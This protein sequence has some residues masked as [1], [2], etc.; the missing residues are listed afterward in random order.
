MANTMFLPRMREWGKAA[1]FA[2]GLALLPSCNT[3]LARDNQRQNYSVANENDNGIALAQIWDV[4]KKL[5]LNVC[6]GWNS[7]L[8]NVAFEFAQT[9]LSTH[10]ADK[11]IT[12]NAEQQKAVTQKL[13]DILLKKN[14]N[15]RQLKDLLSSYQREQQALHCASRWSNDIRGEFPRFINFGIELADIDTALK[16]AGEQ[17]KPAPRPPRVETKTEPPPPA[18]APVTPPV[19]KP[20]V[21]KPPVVKPPVVKPPVPVK[22]APPPTKVL[23]DIDIKPAP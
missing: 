21:V 16:A 19:V 1:A 4:F 23:I 12:L 15:E 7:S 17:P 8:K 20:P 9:I 6:D 13:A 10:S 14:G 22:V 2:V 3:R 18:K 5:G 11:F